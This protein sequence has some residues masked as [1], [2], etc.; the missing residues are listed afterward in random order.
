MRTLISLMAG[1]LVSAGVWAS[2][3][4]DIDNDNICHFPLAHWNLGEELQVDA[5][6]CESVI[7]YV[8]GKA[9]ANCK[10]KMT[11]VP[12]KLLENVYWTDIRVTKDGLVRFVRIKASDTYGGR[13]V[14]DGEGIN[15]QAPNWNSRVRY[16][17]EEEKVIA[18]VLCYE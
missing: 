11:D 2:P 3:E 16:F 18:E 9:F 1:L 12:E 5:S 14:I 8:H 10:C 6:K 13:C 15:A 17:E 7:T 4:V